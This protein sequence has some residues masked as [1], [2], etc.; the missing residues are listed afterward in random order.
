MPDVD[1]AHA[2]FRDGGAKI[3]LTYLR[4]CSRMC[5]G[6]TLALCFLSFHR[7]SSLDGSSRG[8][9][10]IEGLDLPRPAFR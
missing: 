3:L 5:E 2:S 1:A 10:N 6:Q 8:S 7:G 4:C 9:V